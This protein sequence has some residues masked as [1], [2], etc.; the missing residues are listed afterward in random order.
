MS[1]QIRY[2]S[3]GGAEAVQRLISERGGVKE[4][5]KGPDGMAEHLHLQRYLSTFETPT[6]KYRSKN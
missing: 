6:T 5:L 3:E 2:E 4:L 1:N